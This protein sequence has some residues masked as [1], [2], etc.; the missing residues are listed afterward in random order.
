MSNLK[1]EVF[2]FRRKTHHHLYGRYHHRANKIARKHLIASDIVL[3]D[4]GEEEGTGE[5][6]E[7]SEPSA[8]RS[9]SSSSVDTT[10]DGTEDEGGDYL[11]SDGNL[12]GDRRGLKYI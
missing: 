3:E 7:G 9:C 5:E 4:E 2:E 12:A 11:D 6:D 1:E 10:E 8:T